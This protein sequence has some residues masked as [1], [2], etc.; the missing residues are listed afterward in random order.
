[1]IIERI[2]VPQIDRDALAKEMEE[3]HERLGREFVFEG[4]RV[5]RFKDGDEDVIVDFETMPGTLAPEILSEFGADVVSGAGMW[6][7]MPLTQGLKMT[8]LEPELGAYFGVD[9]GVL[10]LAAKKGNDLRLE[11]GDV[12]LEVGENPVNSPSEVM[13]ALRDWEPDTP[14]EI[15]IMRRQQEQSLTVEV[16]DRSL[17]L[18]D[19][20]A[21]INGL[22]RTSPRVQAW[23]LRIPD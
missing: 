3:L 12:I 1:V 11:T 8:A 17:G 2:E 15:G 22:R 20:G 10:V 14:M 7:L 21:P 4:N 9:R 5:L 13:R 23:G 6:F 16:P 19:G 18:L